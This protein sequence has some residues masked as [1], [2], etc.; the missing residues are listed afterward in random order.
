[1]KPKKRET[2]ILIPYP[3]KITVNNT[4]PD[5]LGRGKREQGEQESTL[6]K[7]LLYLL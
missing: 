7:K 5:L 4:T 2:G 3:E 6:L 1:M